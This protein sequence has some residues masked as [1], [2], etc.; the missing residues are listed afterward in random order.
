MSKEKMCGI[1]K[2]IK[3]LEESGELIRVRETVDSELEISRI[4]DE[5]SK[6][7]GGG[8]AL[9]FENVKGSPFPVATNLF[10]S[11]SR[12]SKALGVKSLSEAEESV[13]ALTKLSA[14]KSFSEFFSLAKK[15][16]PLAKIGPRRFS[17]KTAPC[18]EV[19]ETGDDIDLT[20]LPVLKCWPKD[21][22]RFVTLPLVFTKPLNGGPQNLGMYRLQIYDKNTTGMHWHIHKDGAHYFHEY[23]AAKKRMPVAVAIGASAPVIYAATAP[24]P[25]GIDELLLAGFFA[26]EGV[27]TVKCKTVDLEVPADAEFVLEGYVEPDELRLEGPFGDHTGYYSLADYYPVFHVTALT[28]KFAPVYCATLVG[29]PPME[30]C[31]LAKAT[32]RI[33]LPLLQSVFPEIKDYFMPW[34]GVFHNSA[35]VSIKKEYPEHARKLISGLWG[36]GQMSFCKSIAVV[37]DDVDP[38]DLGAIASLLAKNFDFER[39]T[40]IT[41]G[42][43]D[44]LDHSAPTPLAGA[45]VGIDLTRPIDGE[46]PR[47][48]AEGLNFGPLEEKEKAVLLSAVEGIVNM[49]AAGAFLLLSLER[50]SRAGKEIMRALSEAAAA[51]A[52]R[53]FTV[54]FDDNIDITDTS[55]MLW[56][57][58]NNVDPSRDIVKIGKGI[59]IDA[60]KKTPADGHT[61]PWP[62]E[63]F[64]E[65]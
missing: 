55:K 33:F 11:F 10:G 15:L 4:T 64:H 60:C 52:P 8:K 48:D 7:A 5:Q 29:P 22:G 50:R 12:V 17:G 13:R 51:F 25:R 3:I 45:K 34:E 62:D 43:L 14:P 26:K 1:Q 56:K 27:R 47:E 44:V 19:V 49:R 24:L 41:R 40:L 9:L 38:S 46:A 59:F 21:A 53:K 20:T 42:I 23:K 63:L 37:D 54:L 31:Y 39:D 58:F 28:R 65:H 6:S 2:F 36:Q 18:Q 57:V 30:D 61:R 16:A 32:E 35:I